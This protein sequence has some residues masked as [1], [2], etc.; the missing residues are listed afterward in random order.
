VTSGHLILQD[1]ASCFPAAILAPEPGWSLIDCAAAPGNK[2]SHLAAVANVT[3]GISAG[4]TTSNQS[5]TL[6]AFEKD[7]RRSALL[8][9]MLT[10]AGI[11]V[12]QATEKEAA[13]AAAVAAKKAKAST[14][15]TKKPAV[16]SKK[17]KNGKHDTDNKATPAAALQTSSGVSIRVHTG[18]FLDC[19][20]TEKKWSHV[21]AILL[22]PT[23][24]GSG[25]TVTQ[26]FEYAIQSIVIH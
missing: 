26:S 10:R 16:S 6:D 11:D 15:E 8:T 2:T 14:V 13:K 17:G 25:R 23:C 7:P 22:D 24:S 1:K 18:S 20:P 9:R 5:F 3:N 4:T 12:I 21:R 19:K